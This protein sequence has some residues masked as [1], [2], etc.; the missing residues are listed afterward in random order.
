[1][2]AGLDILTD[3]FVY[4]SFSPNPRTSCKFS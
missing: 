1:M 4:L 2:S 3:I